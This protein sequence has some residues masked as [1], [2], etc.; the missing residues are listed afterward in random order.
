MAFATGTTVAVSKTRGEIE[1]LVERYGASRFASGWQ[2]DEDGALCAGISFAARGRLVRFKLRMP[3]R[4]ETISSLK[5]KKPYRYYGA[6]PDVKIDEATAAEQRRRWR[7]L[8]L[9][10][11]AKLESI[12]SGIETFDEAFLANIVTDGNLTIYEAIKLGQAGVRM[13]AP[14]EGK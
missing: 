12:E 8:L 14:M 5:K 9:V 1:A 2:D 6:P 11:K 3:T 13:L 7:C 10:L 4:A